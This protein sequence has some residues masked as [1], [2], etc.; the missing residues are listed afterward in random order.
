MEVICCRSS[1]RNFL[2]EKSGRSPIAREVRLGFARCGNSPEDDPLGKFDFIKDLVEGRPVMD[3]GWCWGG[4][5]D[6][7][8]DR[9]L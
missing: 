7:G 3:F 6:I 8:G 5:V 1:D 4:S 9:S 2:L